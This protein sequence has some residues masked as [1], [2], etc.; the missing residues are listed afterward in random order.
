M[1]SMFDGVGNILAGIVI[2]TSVYYVVNI[3]FSPTYRQ[4][5][6]EQNKKLDE[7][8][9]IPVK[10][11][12]EQKEF[13]DMKYGNQQE[14]FKFSWMMVIN[15]LISMIKFSLIYMAVQWAF[16]YYHINVPLWGA[17]LVMLGLPLLLTM[18]F[19]IFGLHKD[20]NLFNMLR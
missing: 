7:M 10:T 17:F 18:V 16:N 19:K 1:V 15:I 4:A 8:R 5:V 9:E 6:K 2:T 11:L 12:E 13:L 14:P 3:L 20:N